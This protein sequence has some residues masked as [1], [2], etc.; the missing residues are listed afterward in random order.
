[1]SKKN[2]RSKGFTLIE[3]LVVIAIIGILAGV[4][5]VSLSSQ[6][7]KARQSAALQ[8]AMSAMPY[9][10]ECSMRGKALTGCNN[11]TGGSEVCLGAGAVWPNLNTNTTSGWRYW[12][13][14]G[15]SEDMYYYLY[16]STT[17]SEILCPVTYTGWKGA[18]GGAFEPGT[19]EVYQ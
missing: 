8:S 19:C 12:G 7:N 3:L 17:T 14:A 6:R 5:M 13:C 11:T 18:Y 1:M 4:V 9:A 15:T 16:N 10:M 2:K